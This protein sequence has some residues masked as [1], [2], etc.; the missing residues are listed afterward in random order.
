MK[1]LGKPIIIGLSIVLSTALIAMAIKAFVS[2]KDTISVT[3]LGETTFTSDLIVWKGYVSVEAYDKQAA[4]N[5]IEKSQQKPGFLLAF[6][7]YFWPAR[8]LSISS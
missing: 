6:C 5:E 2:S 3:G 8:I 7:Y 4:Y 1:E